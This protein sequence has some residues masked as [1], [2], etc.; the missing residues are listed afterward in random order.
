[1]ELYQPA[2]GNCTDD[3]DY[4]ECSCPEGR[5]GKRCEK[6]VDECA[7]APC[8]N[9]AYNCTHGLNEIRCNCTS[10]F[11]G[12]YCEID[13]NE[14]ES[15]PCITKDVNATC[16]DNPNHYTCQCSLGWTGVNCEIFIDYC[17]SSPC[18]EYGTCQNQLT[19]SRANKSPT[20]PPAGEFVCHCPNM[21]T[22]VYCDIVVEFCVSDPCQNTGVCQQDESEDRYRCLCPPAT[23]GYN[24]EEF[25][26]SCASQPC[27]YEGTCLTVGFDAV[28]WCECPFGQAGTNCNINLRELGSRGDSKACFPA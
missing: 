14:C 21:R 27:Q 18:S 22:G 20:L 9:D 26:D 25:I 5:M 24:C 6:D 4:W 7:S 8:I 11:E 17:E 16:F 12:Y 1:M 13:I 3:I 10:G 23:S 19:P 28:Y 2:S 15:S